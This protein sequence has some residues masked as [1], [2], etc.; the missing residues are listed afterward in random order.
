MAFAQEVF[1]EIMIVILSIN[2]GI[3]MVTELSGQVLITPFN[4]SI[5]ITGINNTS[6]YPTNPTTSG[7]IAN[8]TTNVHNSTSGIGALL[9]QITSNAW[10]ILSVLWVFWEFIS[11]AFIW[12]M[13]GLFGFPEIFIQIITSILVVLGGRSAVYYFTGR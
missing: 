9:N 5:S 10:F 11:G 6:I 7:L 8:V 3:L 13:L 2:G 1:L 4:T 12:G